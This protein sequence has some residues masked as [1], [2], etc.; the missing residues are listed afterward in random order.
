ME[1]LYCD[2]CPVGVDCI[3]QASQAGNESIGKDSHFIRE[4]FAKGVN[5]RGFYDDEPYATLCPCLV[6]GSKC[7][8]YRAVF[9]RKVCYHRWHD[10]TV[11]KLHICDL[12]RTC[13][14]LKT[15]H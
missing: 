13:K 11:A 3:N 14:K 2:F 4:A 7:V 1:K 10:H 5:V 15:C 8:S 12:D 6:I 9:I